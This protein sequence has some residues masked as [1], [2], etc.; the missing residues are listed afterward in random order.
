MTLAA[1]TALSDLLLTEPEFVADM[2]ALK[3]GRRGEEVVP[4]VILG[5]RRFEQLPSSEFPAWV[6]DAGDAQGADSANDGGDPAGGVIGTHQ[7]DWMTEIE[8]A[9][10]WHQQDP[11][12]AVRQRMDLLPALVRLLL[13]NPG[14]E[15]AASYAFVSR[16]VNDRSGRHPTHAAAF[17][18]TAFTTIYRD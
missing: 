4:Q 10:V 11:D 8:L 7:Q 16:A 1:A 15:G 5:N 12:T 9:L 14:L 3:L 2:R 18:L 13:R 17:A 6:L